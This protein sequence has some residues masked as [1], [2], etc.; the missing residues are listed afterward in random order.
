MPRISRSVR[1]Q[2]LTPVYSLEKNAIPIRSDKGIT[3]THLTVEMGWLTHRC[4]K[5]SRSSKSVCCCRGRATL[6]LGEIHLVDL[7]DMPRPFGW[8]AGHGFGAEVV[9]IS[10]VVHDGVVVD[11]W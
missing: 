2:K 5:E 3:K 8:G 4:T 7:W 6:C 9:L 11:G 1:V 10:F